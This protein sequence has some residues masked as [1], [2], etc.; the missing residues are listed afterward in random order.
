MTTV[1]IGCGAGFAGDRF[2]AA[3]PVVAALAH[4]KGERFLI[5]EV[6]AERTLAIAQ[7]M[8]RE[9]PEQ[10]YSPFLD[11]YLPLVL[12]DCR[13]HGI[14]IVTNMGAANPLGAARR[15]QTLAQQ[16]GVQRIKI[17][18]VTGDDLLATMSQDELRR[19]PVIEGIALGKRDIVAANAYL[20]ARS[21]A[22]ALATGADVVLV[23]RTTDAA[24]SLGPLLHVHGWN[25]D[26]LDRL[27]QGTVCG[28][29]LECGAQVSGAYFPDPGL[30]DV[31]DLAR[32]GFPIAEVEADG[33]LI[34]TKP[35]GTGGLVSRAT[36]IEQLLYEVH[37]P[38]NY[39]TPDV[40]LDLGEV[41]V[42][43]IATNRV[44]VH[45]AR[46]KPPPATLKATV[47]VDA[48][49]LGEGEISYAGP[50]ALGRAELAASVVS[51]R[52]RAIGITDPVRVEVLGTQAI[53]DSD[54]RARRAR[55]TPDETGEY[56]MRAAVRTAT[57]KSA[58]QVADEVLSLYCSGP[59][60]GAGVRQHIGAQV[61]TASILIDRARVKACVH[62][63]EQA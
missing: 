23:G 3:V 38:H 7:R 60:G 42:E 11:T 33:S 13:R 50:N 56:R 62:L 1:H 54:A 27:A 30:K 28:H 35:P 46:G 63:V 25:P 36:V 20:G 18:A 4:A 57:R 45:G 12:A 26:D 14:R 55:V 43:Q 59:A 49:W 44:S 6:L 39:L 21:V 19:E 8:R 31:P 9:N 10:G 29:L 40:V 22:D 5:Y 52:C 53:F 48:G 17:A 51:A 16:L 24:L 58:Q 41:E 37:D 61:A 34:I 47:C 15:V 2:D 32:V